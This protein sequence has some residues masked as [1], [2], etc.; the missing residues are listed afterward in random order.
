M[1][2]YSISRAF[3]S[4]PA[5]F[6]VEKLNHF[7][8]EY[9]RALSPEQFTSIA[10]PYIRQ[11]VTDT[12]YDPALIAPMLQQRCVV[13]NDIPAKLDFF[14]T[15]PEYSTELFINKKSKSDC[16]SSAEMLNA[17]IP[18]LETLASWDHDSILAAMQDTAVKLEVKNAKLMWPVRIAVSGRDVT[19]GGAVEICHIL[20]KEETISRLRSGLQKLGA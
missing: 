13:L 7:N 20:G 15:L 17:I 1:S 11:A 2:R 12:K 14:D 9:I 5:I 10:E 6:D 18:V 16:E 8:S 19:P 3:R 4:H